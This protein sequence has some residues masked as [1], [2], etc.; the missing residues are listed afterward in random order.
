[1]NAIMKAAFG[2]GIKQLKN[3]LKK[4]I[5]I[6]GINKVQ[7]LENWRIAA[8]FKS[9]EYRKTVFPED[10]HIKAYENVFCLDA[11]MIAKFWRKKTQ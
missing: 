4:W 11:T 5:K 10:A 9:M 8:C 2:W 6:S 7:D 1:M 3:G